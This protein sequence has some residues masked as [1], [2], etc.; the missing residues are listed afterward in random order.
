ML[1]GAAPVFQVEEL[2][3]DFRS[4]ELVRRLIS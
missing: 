1:L 2:Q 3:E 4:E